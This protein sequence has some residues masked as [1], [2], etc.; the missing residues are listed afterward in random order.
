M[1]PAVASVPGAELQNTFFFFNEEKINTY[2]ELQK[3]II[4]NA[5]PHLAKGGYFLYITCSVFKN[6]NE[7]AV[8]FIKKTFHLELIK[9]E[10]LKGYS[11]KA[12][13]MFA[14][15]FKKD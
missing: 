7:E 2:T 10:C 8:E 5:V 11:Q 15:L 4:N 3:K 9:M 12:D 1:L 6:E 13:S 14:A